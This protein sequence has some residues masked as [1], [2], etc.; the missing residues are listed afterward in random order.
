MEEALKLGVET[1]IHY[2]LPIH[3]QEAYKNHKQS[4]IRF[5]NADTFAKN[6]VTLPVFPKMKNTEITKVI[7][8]VIKITQ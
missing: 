8:T 3:R 2:P 7:E 5:K 4:K 6:L 1:S